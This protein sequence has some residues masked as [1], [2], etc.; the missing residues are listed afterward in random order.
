MGN[1]FKFSAKK[2]FFEIEDSIQT[3]A[4]AKTDVPD[5]DAYLI[6][7]QEIPENN[8]YYF[9]IN[10]REMSGEGG[11]KKAR[12]SKNEFQISFSKKLERISKFSGL[13]IGLPGMTE[14]THDKLKQALNYIFINSECEFIAG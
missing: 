5:P 13:E 14:E 6:L 1:I 11:F 4:F 8:E 12:L 10:S 3:V 7:Q 2:I 9:E